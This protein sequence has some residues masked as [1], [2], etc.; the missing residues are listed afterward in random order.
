MPGGV[1]RL[2]QAAGRLGW[3]RVH[4]RPQHI[5]VMLQVAQHGGLQGAVAL[6]LV[7][8]VEV[9]LQRRLRGSPVA[10]S[11][12]GVRLVEPI[13]ELRGKAA[14]ARFTVRREGER[15]DPQAQL[16]EGLAGAALRGDH[17]AA[18]QQQGQCQRE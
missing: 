7:E 3:S 18:D 1:D 4:Q 5:K 15:G 11:E 14:L 9:G 16:V 13:V 12:R 8:G 10:V 6:E 17:T 2:L